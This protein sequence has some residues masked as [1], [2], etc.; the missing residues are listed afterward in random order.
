M[1]N[2]NKQP[3]LP[4][5]PPET[6]ESLEILQKES[7]SRMYPSI[8]TVGEREY[9]IQP[10]PTDQP[11]KRDKVSLDTNRGKLNEVL[12]MLQRPNKKAWRPYTVSIAGRTVNAT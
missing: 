3:M 1:G 6:K 2:A 8:P 11:V 9:I 5:K 4:R 10:I 12:K 7:E